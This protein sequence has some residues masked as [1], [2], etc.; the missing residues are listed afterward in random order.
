MHP[1]ALIVAG[2]DQFEV[3]LREQLVPLALPDG[4]PHGYALKLVVYNG[5]EGFRAEVKKYGPSFDHFVLVNI[6]EIE[7]VNV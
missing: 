3:E 2:L 7:L 4:V 5:V 6:N 1:E